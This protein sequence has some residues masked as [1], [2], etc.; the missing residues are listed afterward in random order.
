MLAGC[1]GDPPADGEPST[2]TSG[3]VSRTTSSAST[4]QSQTT[5]SAS[6]TGTETSSNAPPAV[7]EFSANLT[8]LNVSFTL[9]A[10]DADGDAL[11]Y[12][13]SFG[14]GSTNLTGGFPETVVNYTYAA[15]GNYTA[16]LTVSDGSDV[17]NRT[18]ALQVRS[19]APPGKP[20]QAY[21]CTVDVP[22]VVVSVSGLPLN[23]GACEFTTT[24]V[25]TILVVSAPASG[26]TIRLDE[27]T[28]DTTAGPVVQEGS[29][30]PPGQYGMR[31][32]IQGPSTGGD[33]SI[34]IRET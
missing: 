28:G 31:C 12:E 15:A 34:T 18:L 29:T 2:S 16:T 22:A 24:S 8:G 1:A 9:D 11:T 10:T 13:L 25:E 5:T 27:N 23:F 6:S 32:D 33:G 30:N 3:S 14:D 19:A 21:S 20:D 26:C 7:S 17:D 4:S